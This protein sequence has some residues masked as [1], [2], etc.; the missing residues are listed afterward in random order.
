VNLWISILKR[1]R[2]ANGYEKDPMLLFSIVTSVQK[3]AHC[4]LTLIAPW[5]NI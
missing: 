1:I 4:I 5:P 3:T 2:L